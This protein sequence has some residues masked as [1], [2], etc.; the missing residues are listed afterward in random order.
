MQLCGLDVTLDAGDNFDDYIW[1]RDDN[2]NGQI[3]SSDPV[4]NDGN[5]DGDL[6]T[7]VV[8]DIGTY[9]VDKIV[10]DPCKGFKEIII[11]ERFGTV[12]TNLSSI[13]LMA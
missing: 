11:V 13:T 3:D 6:S 8:N 12:Q 10:A 7:L 1:V 2:N 4:L 9:I 5:P